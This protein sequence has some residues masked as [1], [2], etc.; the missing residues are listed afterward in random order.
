S[1]D[2]HDPDR[3]DHQ[4]VDQQGDGL[5]GVGME[6][7]LEKGL[8][9]AVPGEGDHDSDRGRND[10]HQGGHELPC[11]PGRGPARS[12][13]RRRGRLVRL[14]RITERGSTVRTEVIAGVATWLTMAYILFVN[15]QILGLGRNG[16]PFDQVLT[17]T[18]LVAGVMTLAMG[19][20]A[21]YP[22]AIASGLGLNA[23]VA[24]SLVV[25]HKLSF[26]DAMGVIV[27]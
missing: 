21:N 6:P 26:P 9:R 17:V 10:G 8:Q 7:D 14:F 11:E 18:A 16:L 3:R 2:R 23:F 1:E 25:G 22:F 13:D 19:L 27:A 15:P 5:R 4:G 12:H 20:F 24:F